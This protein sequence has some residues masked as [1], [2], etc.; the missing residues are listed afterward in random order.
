MKKIYY[1][2]MMAIVATTT[3]AVV[4]CDGDDDDFIADSLEGTWRGRIVL[5]DDWTG[6]E[7]G[8]TQTDVC[9]LRNPY[10]YSSGE[11]YWVDYYNG[12]HWDYVANHITW[13]VYAGVIYIHF[14]EDNS[15]LEI[16]NYRLDNN[17]FIGSIYDQGTIADFRLHHISSPNWGGFD[18]YGY[19]YEDYY[20]ANQ[21][22]FDTQ[23]G[24][25]RGP[26]KL[27]RPMRGT[28]RNSK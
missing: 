26:I 5:S 25:A 1:L 13:E 27:E 12:S 23:D 15:D 2:L 16:R 7:Y 20:W 18:Y 17:Y 10:R 14:V 22:S 4:A 19:D 11:G 9:F 6:L 8:Y 3:I 21:P 24:K 28:K